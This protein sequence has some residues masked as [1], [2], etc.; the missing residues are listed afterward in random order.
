MY[1]APSSVLAHFTAAVHKTAFERR[2]RNSIQ[3]IHA[4]PYPL[5]QTPFYQ[6]AWSWLSSP[7]PPSPHTSSPNEKKTAL[8]FSTLYNWPPKIITPLDTWDHDDWIASGVFEEGANSYSYRHAL[9]C[10]IPT[11]LQQLLGAFSSPGQ[12]NWNSIPGIPGID[13]GTA[14]YCYLLP[15]PPSPQPSNPQHDMSSDTNA[16]T[17][18]QTHYHHHA[19]PPIP[20]RLPGQAL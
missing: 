6:H 14:P 3:G 8:K 15:A 10:L 16:G 19:A 12:I 18:H 4:P 5:T 7:G 20:R 11:T 1:H 13:I 9:C 17:T 2:T